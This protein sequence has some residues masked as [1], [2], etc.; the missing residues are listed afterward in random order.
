MRAIAAGFYSQK[1]NEGLPIVRVPSGA[2]VQGAD[3]ATGFLT[4]QG[5]GTAARLTPYVFDSSRVAP[6]GPRTSPARYGVL[7]CVYLGN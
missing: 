7:P 3:T 1:N 2:F 6:T 4:M 5:T